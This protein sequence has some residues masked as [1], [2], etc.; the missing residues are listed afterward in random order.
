M[1][2]TGMIVAALVAVYVLTALWQGYRLGVTF[3]QAVL[4]LP[5][6]LV[7]RI[8][9]GRI[10]IARQADAPVIYAISHQSRLD[11]ALMLALLPDDTL[12]ILD[13]ES[14]TSS[15]LEPF[16]TLART[17]SFNASHVFV[18]RRLVRHLKGKGRLAVYFP[19]TVEPD[20]KSFRLFRAVARIAVTAGADIVAIHVGGSRH[21][22][23]SLAPEAE[24]PRR[25]L[26]KLT[27]AALEPI[28]LDSSIV[29]PGRAPTTSSNALFDRVAEA[30][31]AASVPRS[32]FAAVSGAARLY[33]PERT[34]VE[35]GL[36]GPL[37]YRDML[38]AARVLGARFASVSSG[39]E[40]VG[41]MLP[42]SVGLVTSFVGLQSAGC[43]ATMINYTAGP[44]NVT[45]AI[46]SGAVR[47]V[48]SS[49]AFVDK[50]Q[51]ADIVAAIEGAGARFLWLEDVRPSVT[52]FEKASAALLW[53]WPVTPVK[54]SAP[55][56]ILFTSGSDSRP[57]GV[58]L[59]HENL[60]SNTAQIEAR[61]VFTPADTLLNVLPAFH[62]Y[63]L[64]GGTI[65]PLVY[66]VRLYLYPSP[67]H[68]K[69]IPE[70]AAKVKPTI[71]FATDTFLSA[72]AR[73]AD[74]GD[75]A[76]LRLVVAGAEPLQ[77]ETRRI[78]RE[79]F[80]ADIVEG[81]GLTE[82][83]PVVALNTRTHSRQG[84]VGRL[85][86]GIRSRIEPV[87]GIEDGGRLWISGPNVMRGYISTR[88]AENV[89]P[90]PDGWH[91]TG[92]V[93]AFDREGY[94]TIRGR[95]RRFAKI[96]GEMVSL[97]AVELLVQRLWPEERHAAVA[98]P[99]RKR[100]EK[101]VVLTTNTA[102]EKS[103]L[104]A[105]GKASGVAE[106]IVPDTIITVDAIPLLGSGKVDYVTARR[107]AMES[108][109]ID[110]TT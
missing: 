54:P 88:G 96:A 65:L 77:A 4:Y 21:L 9:D 2:L 35:D 68:F 10:R 28:S 56:A 12:H 40:A 103:E 5:L 86:P 14:A 110:K 69:Q 74:D 52:A 84:S 59:T 100:G 76:S 80:G 16:R 72:Y 91:D 30:R 57:K 34:V 33:G 32:L 31:V 42:N 75:F 37:S 47:I 104:R 79:R 70:T 48:V 22:P 41:L 83:S 55:G 26:P 6:K 44:A 93:V 82:A 25:W 107:I 99:D 23:M 43:V 20:P 3:Q 97:G 98:V 39:G 78:W 51:L 18:S 46:R 63:G 27:I 71:T 45:A 50:A 105:F 92:D 67:L 90:P 109:G 24:A 36:T 73:T 38:I 17:I 49:R 85:L 58:V 60:L 94:L 11:P 89:T 7:F 108:L 62:S 1:I 87:D 61:I 64:T 29:R 19:Q 13:E 15:W 101:V 95:A 102:A 106:L 81:Y 8:S 66:G 53:R